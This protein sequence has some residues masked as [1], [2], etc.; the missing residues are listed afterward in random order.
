MKNQTLLIAIFCIVIASSCKP[1]VEVYKDASKPVEERVENLLSLMTLEEKIELLGGNDSLG[2]GV[3]ENKRLGIPALKFTDGPSGP[4]FEKAIS[5][6]APIVYAA[7]WDTALVHEIGVAMALDTKTQGRNALLAPCVNIHRFPLGGRNFE[8]YG[9]DPYLAGRLAVSFIKGVQS[10]KVIASVKHFAANNQELDRDMVDVSLDE[11]TLRELYTPAFYD[12]VTEGGVWSV[13]TAYN[14]LNG[15]YCSENNHLIMDLLKNEWKFKGYVISDWGSLHSVNG[16][17]IAGMDLEMPKSVFFSKDSLMKAMQ[18]G[19]ITEQLLND[20]VRRLLRVRF[21]AGLFDEQAK[22]DTAL[23]EK[24]KK[25]ALKVAEQGMV[26]LKNEKNI[27]PLDKSK[28]KSIAVIGPNA[29]DMI[30]GGGGSSFVVPRYKIS[31]FDGIKLKV[32]TGIKVDYTPGYDYGNI[33]LYVTE[34]DI[35]F[36]PDGKPGLLGSY[37]QNTELTGTA[38]FSRVDRMVNLKL[39]TI[40]RIG[41]LKADNLGIKWEGKV[42]PKESGIYKFHLSSDD[43]VRLY[44]DNKLVIDDWRDRSAAYNSYDMKLEAG[45]SYNIKLE[46]FNGKY[47]GSIRFDVDKSDKIKNRLQEAVKLAQKSDVAIVFVGVPDN[48]ESEGIDRES[49]DLPAGQSELIQ[50]IT[51]ANPNTIVVVNTGTAFNVADWISKTPAL[52]DMFFSGGETGNAIANIL[53]GDANPSGKMPFSLIKDESQTTT[54]QNYKPINHKIAYTE[55][56]YVGYRNL[57]KNNLTP[58]FPFGYGLSYTSFEMSNMK[59]TAGNGYHYQVSV[60]VKNTGNREGAEVVQLYIND[61]E[62]SVDR[63]VKELKAFSKVFLKAGESKTVTMNLNER[64]FSF[65]DIK[66]KSWKV[67]SG[68]FRVMVGNSSNDIK[69]ISSIKIK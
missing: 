21:L 42:K 66:S 55:G 57:D 11:R 14:R 68:E 27:L 49:F 59:I 32:G 62:C 34:S 61:V 23:F 58:S 60:D 17:A 15:K 35:L 5:Y 3:I 28:I 52:I 40:E 20:K 67:E 38:A 18:S 6:P 51:K 12:A 47:G 39:E 8:S 56:L 30:T 43:G 41:G 54:F 25:L 48:M 1:T 22:P 24:H 31:P 29:V 7:T 50:A 10:E 65:Y 64:A 4:R 13:M 45:K 53:F 26:L 37:Y 16:P 33:N 19:A 2:F 69:L 9:E 63:P 46:Y 36:S 44:I